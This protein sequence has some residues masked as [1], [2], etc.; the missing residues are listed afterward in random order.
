MTKEELQRLYD[1]WEGAKE[2]HDEVESSDNYYW[3][4]SSS[5]KDFLVKKLPQGTFKRFEV[6]KRDFQTLMEYLNSDEDCT[7]DSRLVQVFKDEDYGG[8]TA[9]LEY[10]VSSI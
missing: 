9:I 2:F 10:A 3:A 5:F 8:W 1:E 4:G 6:H 7:H